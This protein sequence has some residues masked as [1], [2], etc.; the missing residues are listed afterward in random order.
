MKIGISKLALISFILLV[1]LAGCSQQ[2]AQNSG[3][4]NSN[5][6]NNSQNEQANNDDG[7]LNSGQQAP[8]EDGVKAEDTVVESAPPQTVSGEEE[9]QKEQPK[10]HIVK[11][12][13]SGYVPSELTIKN[14]DTIRWI[15]ESSASNWPATAMH[16]THEKYPGS[17]ITKC[18]TDEEDAIFDA[19]MGIPVGQSYAFTFKEVGTWAYHEHLNVKM[20]G[21]ITVE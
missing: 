3:A 4:D 20:F 16:P 18:G 5:L 2:Q 15:N 19:C 11:I 8:Q 1:A 21:K 6:V 10:E 13:G 14:G 17:S 9:P 12:T 7:S